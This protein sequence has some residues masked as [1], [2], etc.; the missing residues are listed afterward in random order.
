MGTWTKHCQ[1]AEGALL[2]LALQGSV[3]I[4]T[5]VW[6]S[7]GVPLEAAAEQGDTAWQGPLSPSSPPPDPRRPRHRDVVMATVISRNS[8]D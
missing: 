6:G 3:P 2:T 8:T 7:L 4:P 1:G 5:Q